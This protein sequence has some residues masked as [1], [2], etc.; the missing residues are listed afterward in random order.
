M[1]QRRPVF[2]LLTQEHGCVARYPFLKDQMLVAGLDSLISGEAIDPHWSN[3]VTIAVLVWKSGVEKRGE[4]KNK[5][6]ACLSSPILGK[7]L[8][9]IGSFLVQR[10]LL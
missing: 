1:D 4:K 9:L 3:R 5:L 8:S 2:P 10:K 7:V 6:V